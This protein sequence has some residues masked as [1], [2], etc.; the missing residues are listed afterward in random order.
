MYVVASFYESLATISKQ[1]CPILRQEICV[2][3]LYL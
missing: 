1:K 3:N 2:V